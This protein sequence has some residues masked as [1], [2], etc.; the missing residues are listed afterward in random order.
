MT[1]SDLQ[2][3]AEH[4]SKVSQARSPVKSRW[5][6]E[7]KLDPIKPRYVGSEGFG[8]ALTRAQGPGPGVGPGPALGG[9]TFTCAVLLLGYEAE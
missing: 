5:W 8:S 1:E 6:Q 2:R 9:C 3:A 7:Q 4:W